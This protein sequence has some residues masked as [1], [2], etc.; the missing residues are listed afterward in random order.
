M[1]ATR[2]DARP[3]AYPA[4]WDVEFGPATPLPEGYKIGR[5]TRHLEAGSVLIEGGKPLPCDVVWEQDI[6]ITLRDGVVI[7]TDVLRPADQDTDLP[8]IISWSAYGKSMPTE[9]PW[10]VPREN[11]SGLAKF[12]GAD[13]AFWLD[14]GYALVNPDVR[15]AGKSGGDIQYWGSVDAHDGYDVIEWVAAQPWSNTKVALYG[16]SWLAFTQWGIAA[17]KPPHLAA[18][19]PWNGIYDPF[20]THMRWGGIPDPGFFDF[21]P[22]MIPGDTSGIEKIGDMALREGL[23]N[24][25]WEDKTPDLSDVTVPAYVVVDGVTGLHSMGGPEAFRRLGSNEK[26]LRI[27]NTQ[28]WHD[29]YSDYYQQDVLRFY[30]HYLKGADNG[31]QDTPR[32]RACI[33]NAGGEDL[34]DVPFAEWPVPETRYE[35]LYLDAGSGLL[36]TAPP[37]QPSTSTYA[38]ADG[39][40]TFTF[41]LTD[42]MTLVGYM[43]VRLWVEAQDADDMDLFLLVEKLDAEGNLLAPH[44][45]H[46]DTYPISPPGAPGRLRVSMRELDPTLSTDFLPVHAFR[47]AKKLSPGEVVPIDIGLT[48][49]AYHFE[50]GQQLRLTVAGWNVRGTGVDLE[51]TEDGPLRAGRQSAMNPAADNHGSH[52]IHSGPDRLSYITVPLI[53]IPH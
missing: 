38:G 11:F 30:D 18:I 19:A 3:S 26:W 28:E 2:N 42:A 9:P 45:E 33:I 41:T 43:S 27:N 36:A 32:V 46:A 29:Q 13:G 23:L 25:Y 49:R 53:D 40:T 39:S 24:D 52:I 50:P 47:E 12:E 22:F 1:T 16:A 15:G 48:P 31:W 37:E 34:I 8:A 10:G 7:Y 17:T 35:K 51:S 20:R 14:K 5:E 21:V 4:E 6:P 44:R